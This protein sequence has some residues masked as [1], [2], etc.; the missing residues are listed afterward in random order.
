MAIILEVYLKRKPDFE[1]YLKERLGLE[2]WKDFSDIKSKI[3]LRYPKKGDVGPPIRITE[4]VEPSKA[5]SNYPY[6]GR[7]FKIEDDI[8]EA[9][10]KGIVIPEPFIRKIRKD[11]GRVIADEEL[12]NILQN[13]P[14]FEEA[15]QRHQTILNHQPVYGIVKFTQGKI[16]TYH[17]DLHV[18]IHAS[19]EVFKDMI[20]V[21][22][23][24][25]A[26]YDGI[27]YDPQEGKFGLPNSQE[28]HKLG[29]TLLERVTS[30]LEGEP[31]RDE[32]GID[33]SGYDG[34]L[35]SE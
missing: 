29:H 1:S 25:A 6:D 13:S 30:W 31:K 18:V 33:T 9:N 4:N 32:T 23:F 22:Q 35:K 5:E 11:G 10:R 19:R 14:Q 3:Y 27:I 20:Y 26:K 21:A 2:L 7:H 16:P 12:Y 24:T 15:L 34:W 28:L 17:V 8:K